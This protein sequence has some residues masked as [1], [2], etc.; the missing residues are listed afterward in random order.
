M[1]SSDL[2]KSSVVSSLAHERRQLLVALLKNV[3]KLNGGAPIPTTEREAAE[4]AFIRHFGTQD[5]KPQR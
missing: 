2:I 3:K 5:K 4:R 1:C